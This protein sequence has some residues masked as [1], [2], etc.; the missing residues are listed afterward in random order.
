MFSAKLQL[1]EAKERGLEGREG[2]MGLPTRWLRRKCCKKMSDK[3]RLSPGVGGK[4][5]QLPASRAFPSPCLSSRRPPRLA[6]ASPSPGRAPVGRQTSKH[7]WEDGQTNT[8]PWACGGFSPPARGT[9]RLV[10]ATGGWYPPGCGYIP[11]RWNCLLFT[12]LNK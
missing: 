1:L 3:G 12:V 8:H 4:P 5:L 6:N 11:G 7:A 10:G 9:T 2:E